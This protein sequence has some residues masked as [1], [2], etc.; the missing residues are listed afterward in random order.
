MAVCNRRGFLLSFTDPQRGK[1][2][3]PSR[4]WRVMRSTLPVSLPLDFFLPLGEKGAHLLGG[5]LASTRAHFPAGWDDGHCSPMTGRRVLLEEPGLRLE[6]PLPWCE[7]RHLRLWGGPLHPWGCLPFSPCPS[8]SCSA[9]VWTTSKQTRWLHGRFGSSLCKYIGF[10]L[11]WEE[12]DAILAS[13]LSHGLQGR[14]PRA[15]NFKV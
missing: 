12:G 14:L 15:Q 11:D 5:S 2:P 1:L 3:I 4:L 7:P 6:S 9:E 13:G 10:Y 8:S